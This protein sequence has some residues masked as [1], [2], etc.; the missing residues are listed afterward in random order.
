MPITFSFDVATK[1][2]KDSNDRTRVQMAFLRLGWEYV[3]GSSYRYPAIDADHDSEDWFNHVVPA[4]MYFRAMVEHAKWEVT[5]YSLDAHSAAVFRNGAPP[6]GAPLKD[7]AVLDMYIP[8]GKKAQT[9]K[10]SEARLREFIEA[11]PASL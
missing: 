3:G 10:L 1:S 4:L 2:V 6:L 8:P 7:S 9:D 11:S 5:R